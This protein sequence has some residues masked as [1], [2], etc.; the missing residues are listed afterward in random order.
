VRTLF[1]TSNNVPHSRVSGGQAATL[2]VLRS[3]ARLGSVSLVAVGEE[4]ERDKPLGE[5]TSLCTDVQIV[6]TKLLFARHRLSHAIT[7]GLAL[8]TGRSFKIA[9]FQDRRLGAILRRRAADERAWDI[10]HFDSLAMGSYARLFSGTFRVLLEH[11][12]E[13]EIF[14]R[15][16]MSQPFPFNHLAALEAKRLRRAELQIAG[17]VDHIMTLSERDAQILRDAD[18]STP[19]S[20]IPIPPGEVAL[21]PARDRRRPFILSLGNLTNVGRQHGTVWFAEKVWPA[22]RHAIPNAEWH[23]VGGNPS[24]VVQNLNGKIGIQVH[25]FVEDL[26]P[27]TDK[28]RVCVVPLFAAGGIRIKILDMLALGIPCVATK[29][30]AQGIDVTDHEDILLADSPADF[31][32]AVVAVLT[33]DEL[34]R[35]IAQN[36]HEL[37][38]RRYSS[39]ALDAAI[40]QVMSMAPAAHLATLP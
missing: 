1:I 7:A 37:V 21:T 36:G 2:A 18:C 9:K 17:N 39:A 26:T 25:G 23:I 30:G 22:V 19:T 3:Y 35:R 31:A 6:R 16:A 13:W 12:V 8:A 10:V 11:N 33:D 15:Y 27:I 32:A 14:E 38:Q 34:H 40:E 28:A 24:P 5:L 29:I 20:T 4:T